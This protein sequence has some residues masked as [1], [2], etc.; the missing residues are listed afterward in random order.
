MKSI[1]VR[2]ILIRRTVSFLS[3]RDVTLG[4]AIKNGWLDPRHLKGIGKEARVES[5][6][7]VA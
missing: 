4:D 6:T 7:L 5:E 2:K 3:Q 1:D